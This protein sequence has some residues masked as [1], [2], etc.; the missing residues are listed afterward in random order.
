MS[1][2]YPAFSSDKFWTA[3]RVEKFCSCA[4]PVEYKKGEHI[5]TPEKHVNSLYLIETGKVNMCYYASTGATIIVFQDGPGE[6]LGCK[7]VFGDGDPTLYAIAATNVRTWMIGREELF[8]LLRDDFQFVLRTCTRLSFH[9]DILEQKLTRS[10]F[11]SAHQRLVLTLLDLA[12]RS[13]R[14]TADTAQIRVTQQELSDMLS[15]SRQTTSI[16]L[17]NLQRKNILHTS[18]GRIDICSLEDLRQEI[19]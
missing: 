10:L 13:G 9:L 6:L 14:R 15:I 17:K 4:V 7:D 19:L 2:G 3:P 8:S 16:C 11:L 18:R 5:I 12:K 1:M